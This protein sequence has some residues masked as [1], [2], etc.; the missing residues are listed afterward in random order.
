[1]LMSEVRIIRPYHLPSSPDI[2]VNSKQD[3]HKL[4]FPL[5]Y[6]LT[7]ASSLPIVLIGGE[8]QTYSYEELVEMNETGEL[9]KKLNSAGAETDGVERLR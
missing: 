6:R 5:L 4:L 7:G 2:T 1:M 3:D 8:P 9:A